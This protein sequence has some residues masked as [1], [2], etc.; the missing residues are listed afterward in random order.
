M[1][2]CLAVTLY[3][4]RTSEISQVLSYASS[5]EQVY[6]YDN[7]PYEK[8]VPDQ[9]ATFND[10]KFRYFSNHSN[11]GICVAMN[12]IAS[13]AIKAGFDYMVMLDQDSIFDPLDIASFEKQISE[14]PATPKVAMFGAT[15]CYKAEL[16]GTNYPRKHAYHQEQWIITAG[17]ALSL[18]AFQDIGEFDPAFFIAYIEPEYCHRAHLKGYAIVVFEDVILWQRQGIVSTYM[19]VTRYFDP[20]I[21]DY[22]VHRNRLYY[23]HKWFHGPKK[24]VF[25]LKSFRDY[26]R[27]WFTLPEKR[28]RLAY[29]RKA[30]WDYHH[31]YM[32]RVR[33]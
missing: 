23:A 2:F 17:T 20:P 8:N 28:K 12:T 32:G 16:R 33:E 27:V 6:V 29:L 1:K 19:G 3:Y 11:D 5:F 7:T 24:W 26:L 21:R 18:K 31:H 13:E 25:Y 4:P 10:P 15:I 14:F 22:Y 9:K 30:R